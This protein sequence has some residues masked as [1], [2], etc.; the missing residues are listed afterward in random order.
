MTD[1]GWSEN[2]PGG[3]PSPGGGA[4]VPPPPAGS[5]PPPPGS[6]QQ[7]GPSGPPPGGWQQQPTV[8][9]KNGPGCLKIGLI[10]LAVLVLFGVI[11]VACLAVGANEVSKQIDKSTGTAKASDY[12]ISEG[13]CEVTSMGSIKATGTIKNTSSKNQGFEVTYRFLDPSGTQL[14]TDNTYVDTIPKGQ[15][16]TYKVVGLTSD[17]PPGSTCELKKVSYQIFDDED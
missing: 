1:S 6:W 3:A 9:V 16:A 4:P 14:S 5:A 8:V 7:A 12:Q 2:V 17:A 11:A 10:I 15:S 13:S